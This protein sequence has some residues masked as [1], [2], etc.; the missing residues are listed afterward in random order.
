MVVNINE[1]RSEYQ[2]RGIN[3]FIVRFG[4]DPAELSDPAIYYTH[5]PFGRGAASA[6]DDASIP[7]DKARTSECSGRGSLE[8]Q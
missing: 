1:T 3:D 2:P 8:E 4:F 6:V 7:D 5:V